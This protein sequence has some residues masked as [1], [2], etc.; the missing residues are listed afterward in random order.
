MCIVLHWRHLSTLRKKILICALQACRTGEWVFPETR[1]VLGSKL[2]K[3]IHRLI[4]TEFWA[5]N[6]LNP[7]MV[8]NILRSVVSTSCGFEGGDP[9][10][11]REESKSHAVEDLVV[12]LPEWPILER[13]SS[14]SDCSSYFLPGE[15]QKC[16]QSLFSSSSWVR[17]KKPLFS[18]KREGA[19]WKATPG[20]CLSAALFRDFSTEVNFSTYCFNY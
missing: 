13:H 14:L 17:K 7:L 6:S 9:R 3:A 18:R 2:F 8:I 11:D 19:Y 10:C 5:S 20:S 12:F 16:S 15:K 1:V 4:I